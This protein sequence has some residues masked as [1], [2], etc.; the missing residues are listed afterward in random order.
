MSYSGPHRGGASS[1]AFFL[2]SEG[3]FLTRIVI[4]CREGLLTQTVTQQQHFGQKINL[5]NYLKL[6]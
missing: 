4:L 1:Q 3:N 5:M 6:F 2:H